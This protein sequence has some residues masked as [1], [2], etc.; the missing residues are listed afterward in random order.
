MATLSSEMSN[1]RKRKR[2]VLT[3]EDKIAVLDHLKDGATQEKLTD[4][5]LH[6]VLRT[7]YCAQCIKNIVIHIYGGFTY[8]AMV[9]P[10]LNRISEVLLYF[11]FVEYIFF[12]SIN[13]C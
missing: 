1:S 9:W 3:L 6:T 5:Y 7:Y 13:R 4:E 10:C 2:V 11:H 12:S 8:L